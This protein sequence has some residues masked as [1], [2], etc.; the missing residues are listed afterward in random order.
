MDIIAKAARIKASLEALKAAGNMTEGNTGS[1]RTLAGRHLHAIMDETVARSNVLR[2]GTRLVMVAPGTSSLEFMNL[3]GAR[4][5]HVPTDGDKVD[6]TVLPAYRY[7]DIDPQHVKM[8]LGITRRAQRRAQSL[9]GGDVAATAREGFKVAFGNNMA[10]SWTIGDRTSS[11]P[12]LSPFDGVYTQAAAGGLQVLDLARD[13]GGVRVAVPFDPDL[14][15]P[16]ALRSLERPFRSQLARWYM[17]ADEVVEYGRW[18]SQQG[19]SPEV[20]QRQ[21]WAEG[22]VPG[23]QGRGIIEVDWWPEEIGPSGTPTSVA[24]DGDGTMTVRVSTILPDAYDT[25]DD[26]NRQVKVTLNATGAFEICTVY[27]SGG[28]NLI[29]TTGALGQTVISTTASDYTVQVVDE[30]SS[31]LSLPGNFCM[32][33]G[34]K[35]RSY[36]EVDTDDESRI[37]K[38]HADL[39]VVILREEAGVLVIGYFLPATVG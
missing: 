3:D 19:I 4:W 33:M 20:I 34:D 6:A 9:T 38:V 24:D 26:D 30:A 5:K 28:Q 17:H 7:V 29:A 1:A 14:I 13:I 11:D 2:H 23:P 37:I 10:R 35:I 32:V 8:D 16:G 31:I 27:R 21:F 22:I 25:A 39:D 15:Y 36:G 18:L 12:S